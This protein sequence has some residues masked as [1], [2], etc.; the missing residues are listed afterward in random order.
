MHPDKSA[1]LERLGRMPA[2]MRALPQWLVWRFVQK[3]KNKKPTKVPFYVDGGPRGGKKEDPVEQGSERDRKRLAPF[4]VAIKALRHGSYDG[5]GFAFLPG[6]GIVAIDLDGALDQETGEIS[7]LCQD[8]IAACGTY[9]EQSPSGKGVHIIGLGHVADSFR[10]NAIGV[11][12]YCGA[13]FFTC[14][15]VWW[16]G[17]PLDLQPIPQPAI[18]KLRELV[19]ASRK[20]QTPAKPRPRA[21]TPV[22][23]DNDFTRVN[24]VALALLDAWVPHLFPDA[25]RSAKGYRVSSRVLG[26]DLE[27]DISITAQGIK[28]FGVADMG[29]PK[30]GGRTAIDLVVEWRKVKPRE[31]MKWLADLCGVRLSTRPAKSKPAQPA[32]GA[33]QPPGGGPPSGEGPPPEEPPAPKW[34]QQVL[35]T[36]EGGKKDCRENVYTYLTNH[37]EL[38]GLVGYDAFAHRVMKLRDAP[39]PGPPTP[40]AWST[41]DDYE[42]G[43]WLAQQVR[44]IVKAEATLVAGVQMAANRNKFHPVRDYLDGLPKW[45]GTQR[46]NRWLHEWCGAVDSE[47]TKLVGTWFVM[48]MVARILRPGCQMD[49]MVVLEG[50]QGKQKSTALRTLAVRPEW[51]ADTPIRIGDKDALLSLAGIWLYEIGELDA[52]NKAEVTA[53]KQYVSSREDWVRDPYGRR[54][55]KRA[56]SGVFGGSTNQDQY[57]KDP[58]GARRMWPVACA[59]EIRIDLLEAGRDQLFAEAL[60]RL[61]TVGESDEAR[62]RRRYWPTEHESRKYLREE[63]EARE[64]SDPWF[65]RLAWWLDSDLSLGKTDGDIVRHCKSFTA[66]EILLYGL[67]VQLDRI[68]SGRQMASRVGVIMHKLGWDRRRDSA[69]ARVWRYYR[70]TKGAAGGGA[71]AAVGSKPP[72]NGNDGVTGRAGDIDS[73]NHELQQVADDF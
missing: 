61:N 48:G 10:S 56:R 49:Y 42:L 20:A 5:L 70:P 69:G 4:D 63:Q 19:E 21:D 60:D 65:E 54:F 17:T 36:A 6:D 24:Q 23:L 38:K 22:S 47:Y 37:T 29:D 59:D 62:E 51:F 26:R 73:I 2:A 41:D 9:T 68:D 12:V 13:Q 30:L 8:A 57:F 25:Q 34:A 32:G 18:D 14:T 3:D 58:T 55:N 43:F 45:D 44:L 15:G 35:K 72:P 33:G 28:D 64:I 71:G 52:F 46:L 27:E 66:Q 1:L 16:S 11:E 39:W 7:Q 53:V 40:C 31:A 50:P 67:D